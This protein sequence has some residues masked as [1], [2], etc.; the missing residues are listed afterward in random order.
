M[1]LAP[2]AIVVNGPLAPSDSSLDMGMATTEP[3]G[4]DALPTLPLPLAAIGGSSA[5]V[6]LPEGAPTVPARAEDAPPTEDSLPSPTPKVGADRISSWRPKLAL[7]PVQVLLA[8]V[9]SITSAE[10]RP[11]WFLS[12]VAVAGLLVGIGVVALAMRL[13]SRRSDEAQETGVSPTVSA[14]ADHGSKSAEPE[15]V[16]P[17]ASAPSAIPSAAPAALAQEPAAPATAGSLAPCTVAGSAKTV[18]PSAL[19]AAGVEVRSLGD[20][21][22]L[23]FAPNDHQAQALRVDPDSL[24][25]SSAAAARSKTTIGHVTPAL[26]AK[27]ALRVLID[28]DRK[29]DT[30]H[31]RRTISIA[32]SLQVGESAGNLVW[33]HA[34]LGPGG[35]LWPLDG[36]SEIDAVR[37]SSESSGDDSTTAIALR[38]AGS[39]EVGL[40]TGRDALTAKGDLAK[41]EGLGPAVGA[42]AIAMNDGVVMVAWADRPSAD[43]PWR[44]R[45]VRFK[46]GDVPNNPTLFTPPGDARGEQ[47]MA[48]SIAAVPGKRF[49]LVWTEGPAT[50]HEVRAITRSEDGTALGAPLVLSSS[51]VNAGQGQAAITSAGRGV[52]AFLESSEDHFKVAAASIACG[53]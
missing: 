42:P 25:V 35:T 39:I 24:A 47:A 1:A 5:R 9:R 8:R 38:S 19:V 45:W 34:G 37:A 22:A 44:L 27:G 52:V 33:A 15:G 51:G 23:G 7:G 18:A 31:A 3:A 30:L 17:T 16:A 21:I 36:T 53:M 40:A 50:Q 4:M 14:L 46:S 32:S 20:D 26:S 48:P 28:S 2:P 6:V 11:M 29:S 13:T 12:I 10:Q 43:V 49:L 41:F